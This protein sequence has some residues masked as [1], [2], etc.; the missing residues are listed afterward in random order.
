MKTKKIIFVI[1]C[2]IIISSVAQAL[3]INY[4]Y[5]NVGRLTKIDYAG[6][7]GDTTFVYDS[8]GNLLQRKILTG[9]E[10]QISTNALVF[11]S[12]NS[13]I[14]ALSPTNIFWNAEKITDDIDGTNLTISKITLHYA[15]TTNYIF[16]RV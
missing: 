7:G 14:F 10:P 9:S 4:S 6:N 16:P 11:P 5:D 3:L 12:A 2:C 1:F 8:N 13:V 15:D